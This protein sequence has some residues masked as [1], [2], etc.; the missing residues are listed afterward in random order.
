[1]FYLTLIKKQSPVGVLQ[2]ILRKYLKHLLHRT[3]P[4]DCSCLI[5]SKIFLKNTESN[6][7]SNHLG[8]RLYNINRVDCQNDFFL[9][10]RLSK[11]QISYDKTQNG[12]TQNNQW[13]QN[14]QENIFIWLFMLLKLDSVT[15]TAAETIIH[16]YRSKRRFCEVINILF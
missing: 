6:D 9:R 14:F 4:G 15:N 3:P 10:N 13:G 11:V 16:V 12:F 2:S 1:M 8:L 5:E 7:T